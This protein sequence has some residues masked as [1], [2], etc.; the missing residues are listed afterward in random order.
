MQATCLTITAS[1]VKQQ[2]V[3]IEWLALQLRIREVSGSKLD[4]E[5][6]Y[7]KIVSW[8]YSA[9]S[10]KYCD[11]SL[12]FGHDQFLPHPFKLIIHLPP[13]HLMLYNESVKMRN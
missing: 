4:P 12:T 7:P 11:S 1:Y 6:G 13:L 2:N 9:F 8:F 10:G 3:V 5:N